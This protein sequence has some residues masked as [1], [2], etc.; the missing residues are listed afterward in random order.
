MARRNSRIAVLAV[1][2]L[3]AYTACARLQVQ[4]QAGSIHSDKAV[5]VGVDVSLL[6]TQEIEEQ[7]Q[8]SPT[9]INTINTISTVSR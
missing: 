1:V 5:D 4:V 9:T 6:S 8:V 7:L 2:A 3:L